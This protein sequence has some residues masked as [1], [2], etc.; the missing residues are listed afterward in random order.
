[1]Y[2]HANEALAKA[3]SLKELLRAKDE[4]TQKTGYYF[5]IE[6]LGLKEE[7]PI[8]FERFYSEIHNLALRARESARFVAAS[9][10]GREMGESLWSICTPEGDTLAN[11]L[12][13]STHMVAYDTCIRFMIDND[14]EENPGINDGD[15]FSTDDGKTGG[16]PHPG[17]TYSYMPVFAEGE[18][19]GWAV[20][21]NHIMEAG[22]PIAGSWP[23]FSVDTS[24]DGL[25]FPPM[26]V[27]E[28][29]TPARWWEQLWKS[30][31]RAGVFNVLDDKMRLAGNVIIADGIKEI[32][33]EYGLDYYKRAIRE[34]IE[35]SRRAIKEN[36]R[37][38]CVPGKF[39][40]AT[41]RVVK[42][43]GLSKLWPHADKDFM[44]HTKMTLNVN[45]DATILGDMTGTS[46]WDYCAF[47]GYPGGADIAF[48]LPIT[49]NFVHNTKMTSGLFYDVKSYY[50]KGSTYNPDTDYAAFSNIWAQSMAMGALHW[51]AITR[52]MFA[53]GYLEECLSVE[54]DWAGIQGGGTLANDQNYGFTNFEQVGGV[55]QG[56]YPYRDGSPVTWA[57]WTQL[58]NI[59]N[60]E[61][62][63][64]LIPP[65]F[66]L[67]RRLV[68]DF[69]GHGK[70]RGGIGLSSIHWV[71][72]P[73][74]DL[75]V[76]RGGAGTSQT[77][78]VALGQ[79][80]GYPA[81][82]SWYLAVRNSNLNDKIKGGMPYPR[83]ADEILDYL[84]EEKIT[85][86]DV[87]IFKYDPP[88][89]K[90]KDGDVFSDASGAGGGWGDP[91][92][93]NAQSVIKDLNEGWVSE[94]I[95]LTCYGVVARKETSDNEVRYL[96]DEP[97]TQKAREDK[98]NARL[99][100]QSVKDWWENERKK[101][102][103]KELIEPVKYM[104]NSSFSTQDGDSF[105]QNFIDFWQLENN[106]DLN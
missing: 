73:G 54:G 22:A 58:T 91:L 44:L 103:K 97:A 59:G 40:G 70:Y 46:K 75:Y 93:R 76:S 50:P 26:K 27:G 42:Y 1:M 83:S 94:K 19:V 57:M 63:E 104:Y 61:E 101:V 7:D 38:S 66:Y 99:R 9:P 79:A 43:K 64:Y 82:N 105:K 47:N 25:V 31:T 28:N 8:K 51:N 92:E 16:A 49:G 60:V 88:Q 62:W 24:M 74:K 52:S 14:Y 30:R 55:A 39:D 90:M 106:Y 45:S 13:F 77:T 20:A 102:A 95:A 78:H 69:C 85:A 18:I 81:P 68:K 17:D 100:C 15:I 98:R 11:S 5:G 48:Y 67:G 87:Q 56:A 72:Q 21:V 6:V 35:D 29:R 65:F 71:V 96:L 32:V 89:L 36:I 12:G 84:A 41:F 4:L 10:G 80:G 37:T 34:V 86:Q 2:K 23:G 3:K 53:K 33:R